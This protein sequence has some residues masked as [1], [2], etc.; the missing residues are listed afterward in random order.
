M[1]AGRG[2]EVRRLHVESGGGEEAAGEGGAAPVRLDAVCVAC[3]DDLVV[4]VGGG[5]R[6]HVGAAALAIS[7]PSIKDPARPTNSSYLVS[8]PGHKEE[9]LARSG[10][11][12]LSRALRTNVVVTVGIHDDGI[13]PARIQEYVTLFRRLMD[14]VVEDQRSAGR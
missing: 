3:G 13:S 12:A 2:L 9:D 6:H 11:L 4:V 10:S 5:E 1:S 7:I 8:V 14:A